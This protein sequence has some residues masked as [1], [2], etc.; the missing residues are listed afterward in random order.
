VGWDG[1]G[2]DGMGWGGVGGGWG[3]GEEG[4]G[5]VDA[6]LSS[7]GPGLSRIL[8][9]GLVNRGRVKTRWGATDCAE[10]PVEMECSAFSWAASLARAWLISFWAAT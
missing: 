8:M 4:G 6:N 9:S 2:W 7:L 10:P 1:M 5:E 3:G